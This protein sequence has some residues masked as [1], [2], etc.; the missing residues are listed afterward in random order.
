LGLDRAFRYA[1]EHRQGTW[2]G[3]LSELE[4]KFKSM[5][6]PEYMDRHSIRE[7]LADFNAPGMDDLGHRVYMKLLRVG[8]GKDYSRTDAVSR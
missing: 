1:E 5:Q 2:Q 6:S 7:N 4:T 8:K 3:F